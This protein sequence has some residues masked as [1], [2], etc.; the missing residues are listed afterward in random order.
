MLLIGAPVSYIYKYRIWSSVPAD[1][2]LTE[3]FADFQ[4]LYDVFRTFDAI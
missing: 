4:K 1:T 2:L 3:K